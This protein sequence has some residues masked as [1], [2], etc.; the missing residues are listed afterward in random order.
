VDTVLVVARIILAMVFFFAGV[1]KLADLRGSQAA[2]EGFRVPERLARVA[3]IALPVVE[4]ATAVLL[5]LSPTASL[6]AALALALLTAFVAGIAAALRRGETPECH[7]FGQL[8]SEP[9]S[10]DTA[11][12]NVALAVLAAVVLIGGGGP[13]ISSWASELGASNVAVVALALVAVGLALLCYSLW[14]ENRRLSGHAAP[15]AAIEP[16]QVGDGV[17]A[18]T[19]FDE[20]G[21]PRRAT[22]LAAKQSVLVFTSSTCG[23]CHELMPELA[24]W[25]KMLEPRLELHVLAA[26]DR[27]Q[28][29]EIAR[30]H[31]VPVLLDEKGEAA[32]AFRIP[33]TPSAAELGADGRV[34][35]PPVGGA[36]G[37]EAVIR[38]A[39]K[40]QGSQ[41]P[42]TVLQ[43]RPATS[44]T[45]AEG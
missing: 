11:G 21:R 13:S 9:V 14:R 6:G 5:L 16:L 23:P 18:F 39:L 15:P 36:L 17:P 24:R 29:V 10:N 8:H 31:E 1:T 32:S 2:L 37:I 26:G 27:H 30:E 34:I 12:R 41:P 28:N 44:A 42:L 43:A 19:V 38:A 40:R 20:Q 45:A 4:L 33:G 25:K 3:G 22:D 7:C 35:V